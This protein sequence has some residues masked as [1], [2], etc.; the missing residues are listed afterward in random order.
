M[1]A[2]L[3]FL[4]IYVTWTYWPHFGLSLLSYFAHGSEV[5]KASYHWNKEI[6]NSIVIMKAVY[7]TYI[8]AT[9]TGLIFS[10]GYQNTKK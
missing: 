8:F 5:R 9:S 2:Y 10:N 3:S 7:Y 4:C 6:E 1:A